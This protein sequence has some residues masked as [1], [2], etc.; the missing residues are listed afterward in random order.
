M[1]HSSHLPA[2]ITNL[3][4]FGRHD[5]LYEIVS[6]TGKA[7]DRIP[8]ETIY[9]LSLLLGS[10]DWIGNLSL[11]RT[12]FPKHELSWAFQNFIH[13]EMKEALL[14]H[15]KTIFEEL[16]PGR[17]TISKQENRARIFRAQMKW[18]TRRQGYHGVIIKPDYANTIEKTR[19]FV[20]FF[21][22]R[23]RDDSFR[24]M[25]EKNYVW[26]EFEL[27]T[28]LDW[29]LDCSYFEHRLREMEEK[30]GTL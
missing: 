1:S 24:T 16:Y 30:Y 21:S 25:Q 27:N 28:C 23:W 14:L 11:F 4:L 3:K 13:D 10:K 15:C 12:G 5:R 26:D 17:R 8:P 9:F 6:F 7:S 29:V 22:E 18:R 19:G 20:R 2:N